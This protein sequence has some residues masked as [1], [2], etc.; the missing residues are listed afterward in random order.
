MC[1]LTMPWLRFLRAFGTATSRGMPGMSF[2]NHVQVSD[3]ATRKKLPLEEVQKWLEPMLKYAVELFPHPPVE[4]CSYLLSFASCNTDSTV[5]CAAMSLKTEV[6]GIYC[7][8]QCWTAALPGEDVTALESAESM[9]A[10]WMQQDWAVPAYSAHELTDAQGTRPD[11]V[12]Q[13]LTSFSRR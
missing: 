11:V 13:M 10:S 7:S 6:V 2:G 1:I 5:W 3:Y 12:C 9:G 8:G 4:E